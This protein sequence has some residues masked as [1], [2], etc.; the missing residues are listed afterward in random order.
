MYIWLCTLN[1]IGTIE[2]NYM[3]Q[4]G[5]ITNIQFYLLFYMLKGSKI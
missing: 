1:R 2:A 4:D 5:G 3:G